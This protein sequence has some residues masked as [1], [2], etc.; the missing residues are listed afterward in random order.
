MTPESMPGAAALLVVTLLVPA[1][2]DDAGSRIR[3]G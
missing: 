3:A 1:C 2:G